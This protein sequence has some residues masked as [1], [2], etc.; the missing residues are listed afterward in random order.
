MTDNNRFIPPRST[1]EVLE[2]VPES[3]LRRLK[4]YSG[5]LATEA[6]HYMEERLPFFADL[7]ACPELLNV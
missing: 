1:V 4:Q 2:N 3:A 6:V 5:R 7:E